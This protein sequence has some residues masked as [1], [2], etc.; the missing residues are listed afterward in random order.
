MTDT[1]TARDL[2]DMN[3]KMSRFEKF[4]RVLSEPNVDMRELRKLSWSGIPEELRPMAW[5]LLMGYLPCNSERREQT[6]ARKRKE[7]AECVAQAFARGEAGLDQTIWH[8]IHIDVPRTHP[9]IQLYQQTATQEALERILYCW[10]IRHPASGY[11]QG[12]N[13]LLTPFFQVFLSSYV[14]VDTDLEEFDIGELPEEVLTVIEADSFW[15]MTKLL[16]GIQD[17]YTHGQPGIQRQI[18]RLRELIGRIDAPLAQHLESESVE[19]IQFSFRW[20][21]C[22][23]MRELSLRNVVR[24]WD[25]YLAEESDGFSDFHVYVCAAFLIK[26]SATLRKM[27]FQDMITFLQSV[28]TATWTDRDVEMLLSEAF[29]WKTLFHNAP[30]HLAHRK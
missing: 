9:H 10:A 25:T 5:Q 11:V 27:D 17:N 3:T 1:K 22:L 8:Q 30:G 16:D 7:Y 26:W 12:I 20:M 24:M 21:N 4:R 28:P 15:C 23:L 14:S 18:G 6:L 13:D 2:L 19:Y 29:M